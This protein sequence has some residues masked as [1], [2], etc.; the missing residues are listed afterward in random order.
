MDV[1]ARPALTAW[2]E[3]V[4][5]Y[6]EKLEAWDSPLENYRFVEGSVGEIGVSLMC[7]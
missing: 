7:P 3:T 1:V 2:I 4:K 6:G 5:K